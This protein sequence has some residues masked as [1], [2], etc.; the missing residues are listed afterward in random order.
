[1]DWE[2]KLASELG[3]MK[4]GQDFGIVNAN[5]KRL[6]EFIL[7][8]KNNKAV[9]PWE[10]EELLD[11]ILESANEAIIDGYISND[12]IESI[13]DILLNENEKFPNQLEYWSEFGNEEGAYPIVEM[14]N[15]V[16]NNA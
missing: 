15:D 8:F 1:M 14:V 3:L 13:K 6:A 16:K 5:G 2:E 9:D 4:T 12:Q 7:Y 10:W 11:L